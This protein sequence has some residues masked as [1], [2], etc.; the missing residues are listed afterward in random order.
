MKRLEVNL[1]CCFSVLCKRVLLGPGL[2]NQASVA[3]HWPRGAPGIPC[4]AFR[5]GLGE[6][7]SHPPLTEDKFYHL[8]YHLNHLPWSLLSAC[9]WVK[10]KLLSPSS[11]DPCSHTHRLT[12]LPSHMLT[13]MGTFWVPVTLALWYEH[14]PRIPEVFSFWFEPECG[15]QVHVTCAHSSACGAVLKAAE[16]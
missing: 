14:S 2:P 9:S 11:Q 7:N 4:V 6:Q 15:F 8:F 5:V 12:C 10:P 3:G 16:V 13:R 1:A